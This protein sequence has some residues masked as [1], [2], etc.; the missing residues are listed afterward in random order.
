M[1]YNSKNAII[2]IYISISDILPLTMHYAIRE[3]GA[4]LLRISELCLS[5]SPDPNITDGFNIVHHFFHKQI[6]QKNEKGAS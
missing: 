1:I 6:F 4:M 2:S 3:M 5:F